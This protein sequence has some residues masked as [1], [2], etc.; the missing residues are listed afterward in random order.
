MKRKDYQKPTAMVVEVQQ[1][2]IMNSS[3][4]P[5]SEASNESIDDYI[6]NDSQTW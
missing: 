1:Q 3:P 2:H 4:D 5:L 6:M